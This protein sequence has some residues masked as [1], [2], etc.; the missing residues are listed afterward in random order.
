M[1]KAE[2]GG[3]LERPA[4]EN[5]REKEHAST[6]QKKSEDCAQANHGGMKIRGAKI[7]HTKGR[8]YKVRR[9]YGRY[10][11]FRILKLNLSRSIKQLRRISPKRKK[12]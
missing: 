6:A 9:W 3:E 10:E 8:T 7:P 4:S 11:T 1:K 5:G 2:L 12:I